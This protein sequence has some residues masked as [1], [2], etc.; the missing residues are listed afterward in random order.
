M[1]TVGM[2]KIMMILA[3]VMGVALCSAEE[4]EDCFTWA[5]YEM[6]CYNKGT[7]PTWEEYKWY[8]DNPQCYGDDSGA[9]I[10]E[11]F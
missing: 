11:L 4:Y 7:E 9:I 3:L 8:C 2:K 1:Y 5:E 10:M 6:M